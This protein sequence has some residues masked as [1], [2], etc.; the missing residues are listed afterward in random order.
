[1][2]IKRGWLELNLLELNIFQREE[3]LV[4]TAL[5]DDGT[6]L[7]HEAC[8]RL[9]SLS[10]TIVDSVGPPP[11]ALAA[12]ARRQIE[13]ALSRALDENDQYFQGER[14]KLEQWAE[15]QI[16]S[17]EKQLEDTKIRI[18]D[19][20]RRQ[21]Q[22]IFDVEDQIEERRDQLIAALERRLH[23]NSSTHHLFRIR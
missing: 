2:P 11:D 9:F 22:N 1:M 4:F 12:A 20:K 23:Q 19:V 13:A 5:A 10:A 18:R 15:D 21:R 7:D 17:A 3:H 8:E 14:D 6:A 16:H